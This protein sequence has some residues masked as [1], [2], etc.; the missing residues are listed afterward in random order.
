MVNL[1][2]MVGG[3]LRAERQAGR[4]GRKLHRVRHNP[5]GEWQAGPRAAQRA[6]L[7]LARCSTC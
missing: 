1:G 7:S 2:T 4:Q 3:C 6:A 5:S